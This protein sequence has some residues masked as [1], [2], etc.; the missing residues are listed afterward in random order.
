MLD[1]KG[2][3]PFLFWNSSEMRKNSELL[4]ALEAERAAISREI[5]DSL[6]QELTTLRLE[7]RHFY[8]Q[9][10]SSAQPNG[11]LAL[12]CDEFMGLLEQVDRVINSARNLAYAL[13]AEVIELKGFSKAVEDLISAVSHSARIHGKLEVSG[14]WA[15][16]SPALCLQMYRCVQEMLNNLIKH[17]Q[18]SRFIV[19]ISRFGP[20]YAVVVF[21]DGI[22]IPVEKVESERFF[23]HF[24]LRIMRERALLFGGDV[25]I[26]TRPEVEGTQIRVEFNVPQVST[27]LGQPATTEKATA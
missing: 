3:E 17:A 23:D 6:G 5:H 2:F 22:G 27:S 7:M 8:R 1:Q 9:S 10:L 20:T 13:R 26:K 24:G 4:L 19:R 25:L 15:D 14:D 12:R 11:V 21:D 18:A 16:P